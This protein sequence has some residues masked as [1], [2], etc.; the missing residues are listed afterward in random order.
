MTAGPG[1]SHEE[2]KAIKHEV[3]AAMQLCELGE[4]GCAVRGMERAKE[5]LDERTAPAAAE[6]P[7]ETPSSPCI[8]DEELA[9]MRSIAAEQQRVQRLELAE[10]RHPDGP[11]AS[12]VR[13]PLVG[14]KGTGRDKFVDDVKLF[15]R[16]GKGRTCVVFL[17][18][19]GGV[20]MAVKQYSIAP[21][22]MRRRATLD[23][24]HRPAAGMSRY[25]TAIAELKA[26][27]DTIITTIPPHKH[28]AMYHGLTMHMASV[29]GR[30][31]RT[32][33]LRHGLLTFIAAHRTTSP[34]TW[35][36]SI[37][38]GE[39]SMRGCKPLG[40]G[41]TPERSGSKALASSRPS[42][43]CTAQGRC[44]APLPS[45]ARLAMPTPLVPQRSAWQHFGALHPHGP[46]QHAKTGVLRP[47]KAPDEPRELGKARKTVGRCPFG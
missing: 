15:Q 6:E 2:A 34:S 13:S 43:C 32:A 26:E 10:T 37:A 24:D 35:S 46:R 44:L 9:R 18:E 11:T 33:T 30:P 23:D 27:L 22:S 31:P 39:A 25:T 16:I 14:R 7:V 20:A 45:L 3:L 19:A 36:S 47:C 8:P 38:V 4:A 21:K 17:G 28:L 1:M 12:R 42:R 41:W 5:V 29:G 40:V